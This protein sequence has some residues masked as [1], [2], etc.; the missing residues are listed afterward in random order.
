L[1]AVGPIDPKIG[2]IEGKDIQKS[3]GF[4]EGDKRS[5]GQIHWTVVIFF[6]QGLH[7]INLGLIRKSDFQIA[8]PDKPPKRRLRSPRSRFAE[9][10][11]GLGECGPGGQQGTGQLP[12]T[13]DALQMV[14]LATIQYGHKRTGV[15]QDHEVLFFARILRK[16]APLLAARPPGL[17]T[18]PITGA[19]RSSRVGFKTSSQ[20]RA[21]VS[22]MNSDCDMATARAAR[23]NRSSSSRL[24]RTLFMA[25][26]LQLCITIDCHCNTESEAMEV[27]QR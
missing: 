26:L 25:E 16:A 10:I 19:N 3:T 18:M 5:I 22:R 8:G 23:A 7:S 4:C 9:K 17:F 27:K 12:E 21:N 13:G 2:V 20:R 6:H 11:H 15:S 1:A 14:W 24:S